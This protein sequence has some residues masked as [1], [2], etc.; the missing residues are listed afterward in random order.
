MGAGALDEVSARAGRLR[1]CLV[2][3]GTAQHRHNKLTLAVAAA[4]NQAH[5]H[6][7]Y[8]HGCGLLLQDFDDLFKRQILDAR[9][10]IHRV[11]NLHSG[12]RIARKADHNIAVDFAHL[13]QI[14]FDDMG[15]IAGDGLLHKTAIADHCA[16]A[17]AA[18]C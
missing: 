7:L 12:Q 6:R 5:A 3:V 11:D 1:L 4:H 2:A 8:L 18:H 16:E 17:I 14:V 9:V 13:G 10:G 15:L